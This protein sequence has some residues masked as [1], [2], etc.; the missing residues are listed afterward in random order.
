MQESNNRII[1]L[2]LVFPALGVLACTGDDTSAM[3]VA[4]AALEAVVSTVE[5]AVSD[6]TLVLDAPSRSND[7][8]CG[9]EP[10]DAGS[11]NMVVQGGP[12]ITSVCSPQPLP[13]AQGGAIEDGTYVLDAL[14]YYAGV[15]PSAPDIERITWAVCGQQWEAVEDSTISDG[16]IHTNR[17]NLA[18]VSQG[19]TLSSNL[20]CVPGIT[21]PTMAAAQAYTASPGHF[22]VHVP[23]GMGVRVDSFRKL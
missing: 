21:Q 11:C 3:T 17:L 12:F 1:V 9:L 10:T 22:A 14:T 8:A 6:T 4:D 16:G 7:A 15:C 13:T 19:N 20:T 5:A 2:A 18:R 23:S